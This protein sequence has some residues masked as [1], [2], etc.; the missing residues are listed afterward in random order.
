M[1]K[2][3]NKKIKAKKLFG[4]T[5]VVVII[6]LVALAVLSSLL[7]FSD[8]FVGKA[9]KSSL[10]SIASKKVPITQ[11]SDGIDNDNDGLIDYPIEPGCVDAF[12]NSEIDSLI[13]TNITAFVSWN[14]ESPYDDTG[15]PA[16]WDPSEYSALKNLV[17]MV[18]LIKVGENLADP[19]LPQKI[20]SWTD[21]QPEGRRVIQIWTIDEWRLPVHPD[22]VVLDPNGKV[23]GFTDASGNFQPYAGIFW[24]NAVKDIKSDITEFFAE[25]K[26][27][28]G[29]VDWVV[30]DYEANYQSTSKLRQIADCYY[31]KSRDAD[32]PCNPYNQI[33]P[34]PNKVSKMGW[35]KTEDARYAYFKALQQDPRFQAEHQ[36][37]LNQPFFDQEKNILDN[38][39]CDWMTDILLLSGE[40]EKRWSLHHAKQKVDNYLDEAFYEPISVIFPNVKYSQFFSMYFDPNYCFP[41]ANGGT[42]GY[43]YC[44]SGLSGSYVGTHQS[45]YIFGIMGPDFKKVK[46]DGNN[47]Y[48][49]TPFN[50]FRYETNKIRLLALS[51]EIP[52]TPWVA[53]KQFN[54]SGQC[55][56][57]IFNTN[58]YAELILHTLLTGSD[59]LLYYNGPK[60]DDII[61]NEII[62]E[63]N[64]IAGFADRKTLVDDFIGWG[65]D[66]VMT[67][68]QSGGRNIYRF[69]PDEAVKFG[70]IENKKGVTFISGNT[71]VF[72]E[73]GK[74]FEPKN[75]V[76]SAGYWVAQPSRQ[77]QYSL[78][79]TIVSSTKA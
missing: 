41:N 8:G 11:C 55:C 47:D 31:I 58:Y 9:F 48:L 79:N 29:K 36:P 18:P 68:M 21:T 64:L 72:I 52:I 5:F 38:N 70:V 35:T 77:R 7:Y 19:L 63:F 45:P 61:L 2:V 23:V 15:Y 71:K 30:Q 10:A 33:Q 75:K 76:S 3:K 69:T 42:K 27:I 44:F 37:F 14:S 59:G 25:Y 62:K 40:C 32:I 43:E 28:G 39:G 67:G 4:K 73:N 74:I 6:A 1:K 57:P 16:T 78:K 51:S 26:S 65:D 46:L 56:V 22:D 12:D 20:K 13:R 53:F 49:H 54:W 60:E 66:Y 34:A 50:A 24:D 17:V